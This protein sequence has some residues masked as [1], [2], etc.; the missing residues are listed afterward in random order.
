[1]SLLD[2]VRQLID[3]GNVQGAIEHVVGLLMAKATIEGFEKKLGEK[4]LEK[5][6]KDLQLAGGA[7]L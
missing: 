2:S 7:V 1:M 3:A 5:G 6:W 4:I